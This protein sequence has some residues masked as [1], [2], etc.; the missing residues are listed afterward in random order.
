MRVIS[1]SPLPPAKDGIADYAG[2][3]A[4]AY[5]AC[6]TTMAAVTTTPDATSSSMPVLGLVSWS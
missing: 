1:I 6:D 4:Q 3:L 5:A 2:K